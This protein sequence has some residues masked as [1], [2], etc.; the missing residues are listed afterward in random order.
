[1]TSY[2][3]II[4]SNETPDLVTLLKALGH[5][6]IS[7]NSIEF[8]YASVFGK[9]SNNKIV[10]TVN[11]QFNSWFDSS[12]RKGGKLMDFAHSYWPNLSTAQIEGKLREIQA[13]SAKEN[14][15]LRKRKAIRI[16]DYRFA[17]AHPLGYNNEFA[18][19]LLESD[20]LELSDLNIQEVHYYVIDQKGKRKDFCAAGWQNENGGWEVRAQK[21][22]GCIGTK[23]MTFIPGSHSVLAI[24]P[25]YVDFLKRR[26]DEHLYYASILILNHPEFLSAALKRASHFK[27]VLSY[28]D[29]MRLGYQS[30]SEVF[31]D[32]LPHAEVKPL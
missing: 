29:D 26:N 8:G 1:M 2:N 6:P 13:R 19:F 31:K 23:G 20:L 27:K 5:E 10:L 17:S 16:P 30:T 25:E 4:P 15:P 14:R 3:K 32:K 24:F 21:Y 18:D 7:I 12:L 22:S 9:R 11:Q 28:I